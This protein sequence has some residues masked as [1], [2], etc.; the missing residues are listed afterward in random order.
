MEYPI[1]SSSEYA[2]LAEKIAATFLHGADAAG[3]CGAEFAC[4]PI[5]DRPDVGASTIAAV[6][7]PLAKA[8]DRAYFRILKL[9]PAKGKKAAKAKKHKKAKGKKPNR[10]KLKGKGRGKGRKN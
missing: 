7:A 10:G 9:K 6:Q 1:Q 5:D 8:G 3:T 2:P 4:Q